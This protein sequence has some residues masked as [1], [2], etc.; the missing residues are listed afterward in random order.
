MSQSLHEA[1]LLS[2]SWVLDNRSEVQV[3]LFLLHS[4]SSSITHEQRCL[5]FRAYKAVSSCLIAVEFDFQ[6]KK[7]ESLF[8]V[9]KEI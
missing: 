3:N 4:S 8:I 1:V 7:K 2:Y 6:R 5:L 9:M